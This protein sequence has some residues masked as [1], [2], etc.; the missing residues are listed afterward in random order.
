VSFFSA[1]A[2]KVSTSQLCPEFPDRI[3]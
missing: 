3:R 2:H 1:V